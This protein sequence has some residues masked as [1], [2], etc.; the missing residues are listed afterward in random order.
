MAFHYRTKLSKLRMKVNIFFHFF[1]GHGNDRIG[2][3]IAAV[4]AEPK[5][6]RKNGLHLTFSPR[7]KEQR[8]SRAAHAP[9]GL[10]DH[11]FQAALAQ[12][13]H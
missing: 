12:V 5:H 3:Q 8:S 10:S 9:S 11:H 1:F 2:L 7:W 4:H 6:L 13:G